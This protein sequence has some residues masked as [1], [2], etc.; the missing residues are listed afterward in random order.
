MHRLRYIYTREL[1]KLGGSS[2]SKEVLNNVGE[3]KHTKPDWNTDKEATDI[4][5][6][7]DR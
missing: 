2:G 7:W 3:R 6:E 4:Y 1:N 5:S